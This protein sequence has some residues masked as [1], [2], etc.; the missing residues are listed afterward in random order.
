MKD[1]MGEEV[2]A[3]KINWLET[4]DESIPADT[5]GLWA[6]MELRLDKKTGKRVGLYRYWPAAV[7]AIL[8][9]TRLQFRYSNIC[10]ARSIRRP[11]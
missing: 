10:R 11:S 7:A 4:E 2:I 9:V 8:F 1:S 3:R 6:K 5:D